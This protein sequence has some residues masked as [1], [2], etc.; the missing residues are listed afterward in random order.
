[1][2]LSEAATD[3]AILPGGEGPMEPGGPLEAPGVAPC[4]DPG[5]LGGGGATTRQLP[6]SKAS[7]ITLVLIV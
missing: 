6:I 4:V 3:G 5:E 7:K 1:V 2:A